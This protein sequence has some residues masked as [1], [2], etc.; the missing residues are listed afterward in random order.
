M[1]IGALQSHHDAG[2]VAMRVVRR[3]LLR[4]LLRLGNEMLQLA[5]RHQAA[6]DGHAHV[7]GA[8]LR[9][10]GR[11]GINQ[12]DRADGA[13]RTGALRTGALRLAALPEPL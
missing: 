6:L 10:A 3:R 4:K 1:A 2:A 8:D 11:A 13:L 5:A 7:A 9:A 12:Q